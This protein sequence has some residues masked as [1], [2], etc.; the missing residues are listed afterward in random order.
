MG[1]Y[2]KEAEDFLNKV[3]A[4]IT[5]IKSKYQS[6]PLW[7]KEGDKFGFKYDV[8][9]ERNNKKYS[10]NFWNSIHNREQTGNAQNLIKGELITVKPF[11]GKPFE[12][13]KGLGHFEVRGN[14]NPIDGKKYAEKLIADYKEGKFEP[15]AYDILA[16]L[17]KYD[18][19]TFADFCADYGY[20]E[21][22]KKAEKTFLAV[23]D[24][25]K[26]IERLFGDV[27]DEL[28]EIN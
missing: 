14:I 3:N 17:T 12:I 22:S 26:N 24:E 8:T 19:G 25:Y 18:P 28:W 13:K 4:K 9:I 27:M 20:D 7:T 2:I 23:I 16:S 21:D 5:I 6:A 1:N 11:F 15:N 10:F